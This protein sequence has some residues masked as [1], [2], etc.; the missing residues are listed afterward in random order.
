MASAATVCPPVTEALCVKHNRRQ[1][2]WMIQCYYAAACPHGCMSDGWFYPSC[3]GVAHYTEQQL[4]QPGVVFV[5]HQCQ[6]R[7]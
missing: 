7:T 4:S 3:A 1:G 2:A 5:C 6:N